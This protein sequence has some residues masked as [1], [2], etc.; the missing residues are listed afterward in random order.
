MFRV[1]DVLKFVEE[2]DVKFVRLTFCDPLGIVKNV[3]LIASELPTA[4]KNGVKID[5][6]AIDGFKTMGEK[7]LVLMPDPST[8]SMLPWRPRSSAV[9]RLFCDVVKTDGTPFDGDGRRKLE[10]VSKELKAMGMS[11]VIGTDCQFYLFATDEKG[12]PTTETLD[13]AE[14]LDVA[15][16][17][18]GEDIRRDICLT[19]DSLGM[20]PTTSHHEQGP[21]QNEIDFKHGE[22]TSAADNFLVFKLLVKAISARNGVYATFTPCPVENAPANWLNLDFRTAAATA[23]DKEKFINGIKERL[24]DLTV[25]LNPTAEALQSGKTAAISEGEDGAVKIKGIDPTCNPYIALTLLLG[26][27]KDGVNGVKK[28]TEEFIDDYLS[29]SMKNAYVKRVAELKSGYA[30]AKDKREY[31]VKTYFERT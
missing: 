11:C 23:T 8:M 26:A 6:R 20:E 16:L 12:R 31:F 1:S 17:D 3:S 28:P 13:N 5:A 9:I 21:G 22:A 18:K 4:F 24:D 25:F 10:K 2:N 19:L 27:G 14:Y 7:E 29:E 15:P 30:D